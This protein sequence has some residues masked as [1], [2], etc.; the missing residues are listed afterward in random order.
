VSLSSFGGSRI[1]RE[2]AAQ[3]ECVAPCRPSDVGS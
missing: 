1:V 2:R 3:E